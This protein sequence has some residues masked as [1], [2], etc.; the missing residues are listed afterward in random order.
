MK[1]EPAKFNNWLHAKMLLC[2]LSVAKL[3]RESGLH[4]NT[5]EAYTT[6]KHLPSLRNLRFVCDALAWMIL[7]KKA[8]SKEKRKLSS[9]LMLE[10]IEHV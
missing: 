3:A 8:T 4:D 7:G 10:A 5:I 1:K 9:Q 2:G 6:G